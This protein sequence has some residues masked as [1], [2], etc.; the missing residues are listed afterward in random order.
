M[1]F[2]FYQL[3][4]PLAIT[5]FVLLAYFA[6]KRNKESEMIVYILVVLLQPIF[7]IKS[8]KDFDI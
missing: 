1:P 7:K 6:F 8:G 2:E 4:R 3:V 5:D